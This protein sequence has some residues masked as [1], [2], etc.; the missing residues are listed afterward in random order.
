VEAFREYFDHLK[1]DG[2]IAITRWE[3]RRPR[4]ALRVVSQAIEALHQ[5]GVADP[6]R[7]FVVVADGGLNED[8]RP[9]L[10]LAKKSPF[11]SAEYA[12]VAGHMGANSNLVW[13]NP[14]PEYA[15]VQSLPPAA[16]AFRGL[17]DSN[18]PRQ[19]G[20]D[21]AYNVAPV[22]DTAPF[23]FFTLKT[24]Y[25]L[26][27]IMAGTGR[28][29][30][31]RI[32][33]GVVVLGML[34]LISVVAVLAF[35]VLPLLLHGR[36]AVRPRT[37]LAA[38]LYFIAVGIGYI[39]VEISLI[40][41]F[42]LFLGHPTYALTVVVFL[43]LLSSGAGSLAARRRI[44]SASRLLQVLA[45]IGAFILVCALALPPLLSAAVGLPFALKLLISAVALTPLG[46][47]MGMPFPTGLRLVA[48][49]EWAWALNA[50]AS[51]L[52]SVTAMVVAIHFGLTITLLCAA[53]AYLLAALFSSTW[54][55]AS[56]LA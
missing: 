3:F 22:N 24:G 39:T 19:F 48:A 20:R 10:V 14:P 55:H 17:I 53:A 35:L 27:N 5:M 37:G 32:N 33:L 13:L 6:R 46:F 11:T 45:G 9:V 31:W 29:M 56:A 36:G 28:G 15:G 8:G 21:Y 40:Q 47:L 51:V 44:S 49:V 54:R 2:M 52:G 41:R 34:L 42:V 23:F 38:L 16:E 43:M 4:E 26:K 30:D 12:A 18:D 50:A 1:P 7:H 25:V